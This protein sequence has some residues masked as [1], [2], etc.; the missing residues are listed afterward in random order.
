M[1]FAG[2]TT[3]YIRFFHVETHHLPL[4]LIEA[5]VTLRPH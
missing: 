1:H 5:S 3:T 2:V 4:L